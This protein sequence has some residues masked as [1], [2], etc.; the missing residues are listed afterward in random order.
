MSELEIHSKHPNLLSMKTLSGN[1]VINDREEDLGKIEDFIIDTGTGRVACHPILWGFLG[2]GDKLFAV[3]WNSMDLNT[4]RHA[5]TLNLDKDRLKNAQSF[6]RN[7]W[8]DIDNIQSFVVSYSHSSICPVLPIIGFSYDYLFLWCLSSSRLER[9][10]V[11]YCK[12]LEA[13]YAVA[14]L[15]SRIQTPQ[16]VVQIGCDAH[17]DNIWHK[18]QRRRFVYGPE[19]YDSYE[20]QDP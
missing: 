20:N 13:G 7:R 19:F 10:P 2:V 9:L 8:T 16:S 11:F 18:Q 1:R 17:P 12:L 4:D 15:T 6:N 3:P 14:V 5:F